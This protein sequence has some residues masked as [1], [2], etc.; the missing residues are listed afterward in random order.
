VVRLAVI[1][2][3]VATVFNALTV[4]AGTTE[5]VRLPP[6]LPLLAGPVTLN[7]VV[8]GLLSGLA[9][10]N[11]VLASALLGSVVDWP[12]ALRL[13]P[14][15]LLTVAVAGSIAIAFVPQTIAALHEIREAQIARGYRP[16]GVRDVAPLLVPLL[17]GGLERAI[18]LAEALESRAFGAPPDTRGHLPAWRAS[19]TIVGITAGITGGYLLATGRI[20]FAS[21]AAGLAAL[22]LLVSM[23][24]GGVTAHRT[25]YRPPRLRRGDLAVIAGAMIAGGATV[26]VMILNPE[27]LRY[28]PYPRLS[29]PA[30]QVWYLLSQAALVIPA[31]LAPPSE[32]HETV[33]SLVTPDSVEARGARP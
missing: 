8:Y 25:R 23:R 7:A 22:S 28:E 16:Q 18:T 31:F 2:A 30:V 11:L 9:L 33:S 26:M 21:A 5:L 29:L 17:H 1:F 15:R 4:R 20:G 27:A 3:L 19:A 14:D 12:A 10:L 24:T 13:I 6:W 32:P